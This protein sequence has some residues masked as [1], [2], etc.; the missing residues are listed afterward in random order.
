MLEKQKLLQEIE[1][2]KAARGKV[3]DK[4]ENTTQ[5]EISTGTGDSLSS[6]TNDVIIGNIDVLRRNQSE[7]LKTLQAIQAAQE[8]ANEATQSVIIDMT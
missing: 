7:Q 8:Q 5:T 3:A 1:T 4:A 6:M 2:L